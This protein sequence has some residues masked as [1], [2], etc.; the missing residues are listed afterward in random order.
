MWA[1]RSEHCTGPDECTG[2]R[3]RINLAS[4]PPGRRMTKGVIMH[5]FGVVGPARR[6]EQGLTNGIVVQ[7]RSEASSDA[8]DD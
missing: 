2:S 5:D 4:P 3:C 7:R 6:M 1:G 8:L